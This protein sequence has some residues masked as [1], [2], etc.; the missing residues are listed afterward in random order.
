MGAWLYPISKRP[1]YTF[2]VKGGSI[3]VSIENYRKLVANGRLIEDN[4]WGVAMLIGRIQPNDEIFIYTGD[5]DMG[6]IG[7]ATVKSVA[8][9][10]G[11]VQLDFDL[12]RCRALLGHPVPAPV[13]RRWIHYPRGAVCDLKPHLSALGEHLPWRSKGRTEKLYKT[14]ARDALPL[15]VRHAK[16]AR[17]AIYSDLAAELGMPNPRNLNYVLGEVGNSLQALSKEWGTTV[18]PIQFLVH[19]KGKGAPGEGIKGF[20]KEFRG[21]AKMPPRQKRLLIQPLLAR[22]YSFGRWDEVLQH[23]GLPA[24][25]QVATAVSLKRA[26]SFRG[27]EGESET[28]RRLKEFVAK[29]PRCVERNLRPL[30]TEIEFEFPSKDK[31]DVLFT[32]RTRRLAVEVKAVN[33]PHDDI[34]RGL[35]QCVKYQAVGRAMMAVLGIDTEVDAVLVLEDSLPPDLL[36]V[37]SILGVRVVE[38]VVPH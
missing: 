34:L 30:S 36:G 25:P 28:H 2:R 3:P 5:D 21:Y 6:I 33:S 18:P 31:V 29:N 8:Q 14:R 35:F 4:E 7:Y 23:F 17:P 22:I 26:S 37:K 24:A 32:C 27:G 10:K 20:S 12:D 9:D 19:K 38:K 11:L 13:V 15:L 16:A 1:H